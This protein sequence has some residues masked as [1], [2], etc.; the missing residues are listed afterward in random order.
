MVEP[1]SE[2]SEAKGRENFKETECLWIYL[3]HDPGSLI[4]LKKACDMSPSCTPCPLPVRSV[5]G[6][7][8]GQSEIITRPGPGADIKG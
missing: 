2:R 6:S 7:W 8:E 1:R 5:L 3:S 4:H